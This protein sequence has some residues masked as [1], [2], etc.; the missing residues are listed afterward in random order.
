[1]Y[2]FPA[3]YRKL[4]MNILT[5]LYT[6]NQVLDDL[7]S[8]WSENFSQV[9]R[10]LASFLPITLF[11]KPVSSLSLANSVCYVANKHVYSKCILNESIVLNT[12]L[13]L[14]CNNLLKLKIK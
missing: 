11:P 3:T 12:R 9:F 6:S 7:L 2:E 5:K 8:L 10:K 14:D 4:R 13:K 1:M